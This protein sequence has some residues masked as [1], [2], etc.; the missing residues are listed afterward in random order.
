MRIVIAGPPKSGNAQL[1]CLVAIMCDLQSN[2]ARDAPREGNFSEVTTWMS[3]LPEQSVSSA[4]LRYDPE[5]A[6]AAIAQGIELVAIIRHPYDLFVSGVDVARQRALKDMA[7]GRS[8]VRLPEEKPLDGPEIQA[9]ARGAFAAEVDSLTGW[10]ESGLP[11]VRFEHLERDPSET[12]SRLSPALGEFPAD[13]VAR[14]IGIC[15][16]ESVILGRPERG[17]RAAALPSGS[18]RNRLPG[19]TLRLLQEHYTDAVRLLGYEP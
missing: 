11:L 10:H 3:S 9:Y 14:A 16:S 17:T 2:S 4:S 1:R 19:S 5:I 13:R 12:L 15:P 6:A 18:W 8:T 7:R